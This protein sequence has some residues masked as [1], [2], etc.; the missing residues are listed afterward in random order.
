MN[1][2]CDE[3]EAMIVMELK[4]TVLEPKTKNLRKVIFS[5][6]ISIRGLLGLRSGNTL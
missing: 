2:H 1:E 5:I 6:I 4:V 3:D